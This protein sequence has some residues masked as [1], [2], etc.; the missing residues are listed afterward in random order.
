MDLNNFIQRPCCVCRQNQHA[1]DIVIVK[2]YEIDFSLLKNPGI[3]AACRPTTYNFKEYDGAILY[4]KG[5]QDL[6]KKGLM[7]MCKSCCHD[8][9]VRKKQPLNAIANYQYYVIDE[10]PLI[11]KD[12][13]STATTFEV[14]LVAR[15]RA[16]WLTHLYCKKKNSPNFMNKANESQC[17]SRGNVAILPQDTITLRTFLPPA[18]T[19][20]AESMP[21]MFTNCVM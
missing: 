16:T 5:L 14:K 6:Q 17:Y 2:P 10:L 4:P 8:L 1:K 12:A 11:A 20:I 9:V 21:V 3:P 18:A 7:D 13:F 15:S 19:E